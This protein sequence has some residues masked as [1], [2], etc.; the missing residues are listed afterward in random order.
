M[1]RV[2]PCAIGQ[3]DVTNDKKE[4]DGAT[5]SGTHIITGMYYR[6]DR[7]AAPNNWAVPIGPRDLWSDASSEAQY[8]LHVR[9]PYPHSHEI[10]RRSDPLYDMVLITDWN[11]PIATPGKG[12][13]IFLHVWRRPRYPTAGCVAFSKQNLHWI[14]NRIAPGTRLIVPPA[15]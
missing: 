2:L 13:A 7:M 12:S 6:P 11:W 14:V 4:G 9:A 3:G 1:G 5:P 8:N 10:M 15:R